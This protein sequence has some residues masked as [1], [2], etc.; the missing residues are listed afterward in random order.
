LDF[1]LISAVAQ[2]LND[3]HWPARLIA[4]YLLA[5]NQ[6]R[7]FDKVLNWTAERDS[8]GLVRNMAIA[9]GAVPQQPA[10][11]PLSGD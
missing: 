11:K 8:S 6:D 10:D 2:N 5:K 9:L 7:N 1:E 4:L 3:D